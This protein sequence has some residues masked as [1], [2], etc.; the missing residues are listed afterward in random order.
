MLEGWKAVASSLTT[1]T[2]WCSEVRTTIPPW[3]M[4]TRLYWTSRRTH[5]AR[6]RQWLLHMPMQVKVRSIWRAI[7]LRTVTATKKLSSWAVK[8]EV[9]MRL[10]RSRS[11]M[12]L[13]KHSAWVRRNINQRLKSIKHSLCQRGILGFIYLDRF[14]ILYEGP[15]QIP[16]GSIKTW[17]T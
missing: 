9:G 13:L 5:G 16:N 4:M 6:G 15:G 12:S 10:T 3:L 1:P 14:M 2:S 7:S 11:T 17:V 8:M